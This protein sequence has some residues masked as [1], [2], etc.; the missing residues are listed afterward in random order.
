MMYWHVNC[1]QAT[2][3][4]LWHGRPRVGAAVG[5]GGERRGRAAF[6]REP[7]SFPQRLHL[8]QRQPP[9]TDPAALSQQHRCQLCITSTSTLTHSLNDLDLDRI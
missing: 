1:K 5:D 3:G 9:R 8:P 2:K 6:G 7:G 4:L